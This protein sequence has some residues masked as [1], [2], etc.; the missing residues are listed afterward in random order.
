MAETRQ[1]CLCLGQ[2]LVDDLPERTGG[3]HVEAESTRR[4]NPTLP[5]TVL[6]DTVAL[7]NLLGEKRTNRWLLPP[8]KFSAAR[9]SRTLL[10]AEAKATRGV[11]F[12]AHR[13]LKASEMQV[14]RSAKHEKVAGHLGVRP[15]P[16]I[17]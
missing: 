8:S 6:E 15:K 10:A 17:T 16:R 7:S 9:E 4:E 5:A 12:Q 3:K 2:W 14:V 13:D 11:L 1:W